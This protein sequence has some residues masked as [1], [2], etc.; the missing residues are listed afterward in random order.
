MAIARSVTTS[1]AAIA[2]FERPCAISSSTSRSRA[3][4]R[5]SGS[6]VGLPPRQQLLDHL[7]VH[8]RTARR[9]PTYG[10]HELLRVEHPV[11]QQ[12]PDR[13]AAVGEQLTRVQLLHVLGEHQHRQ[14]GS[15]PAG[16][17]RALQA[18]VGVG[19]RQAYVDDGDVRLQFGQRAGQ[20]GARLDGGGDLEVVG[21]QQPDESVAQQEQVFG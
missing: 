18:L 16:L 17:E 15:V 14:P 8:R 1:C 21:L 9:D 10:V 4:S 2:A 13:A 20:L 11:L 6:T 7:R 5:P 12:I 19:R 3:V